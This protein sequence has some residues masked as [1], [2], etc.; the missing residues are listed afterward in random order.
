MLLEGYFFGPQATF[1]LVYRVYT[2]LRN[3]NKS[4]FKT[5]P[6]VQSREIPISL[7]LLCILQTISKL[8]TAKLCVPTAGHYSLRFTDDGGAGPEY[9]CSTSTSC[10][11]RSKAISLQ[12]LSA[13][14]VGTE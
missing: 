8:I 7:N 10:L 1:I 14:V 11:R 9:L 13:T 5:N 4:H 6:S 3:N 12:L 2:Y